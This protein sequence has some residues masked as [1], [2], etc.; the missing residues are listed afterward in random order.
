M[1]HSSIRSRVPT[2]AAAEGGFDGGSQTVSAVDCGTGDMLHAVSSAVAAVTFSRG[3][4]WSG[5]SRGVLMTKM[6]ARGHFKVFTWLGGLST[7]QRYPDSLFHLRS[8]LRGI[9][10]CGLGLLVRCFRLSHVTFYIWYVCIS[11]FYWS[12]VWKHVWRKKKN[13][14]ASVCSI[15]FSFKVS[16][17][18]WLR[19]WY[20]GIPIL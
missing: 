1:N 8:I 17:P 10:I 18:V 12:E 5:G 15:F 14:S 19:N 9:R 20:K 13:E 16:F 2:W 4:G 11:S 3:A 7:E 6:L